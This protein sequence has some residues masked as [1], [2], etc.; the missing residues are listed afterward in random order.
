MQIDRASPQAPI[1][2]GGKRQK[3]M[4]KKKTRGKKPR[5]ARLVAALNVSLVMEFVRATALRDVGS[6]WCIGLIISSR[7]PERSLLSPGIH[8]SV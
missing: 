3:K 2:M 7:N 8:N 6:R 5:V 1:K 4:R